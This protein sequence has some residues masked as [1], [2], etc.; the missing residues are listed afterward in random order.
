MKAIRLLAVVLLVGSVQSASAQRLETGPQ[1]LT[2]YSDVDDTEQPY[3]IYLP[4]NFDESRAYPLVVS[5]H[6]AGSNHRLNLKRVF[7]KTNT[8]GENDV[9][10]SRYF[11]EWRDVDY[12]VASPLARGT[13]GYQGVAEKDVLDMLAD[14]ER[15]FT[16]DPNRRYLTGLSMGGGGTL[17][18]GASRPDL[19]AAIVPVCPAP[20]I[21]TEPLAMN[22]LNVPVYI[23]QGDA[24]PAVSPEATRAWVKRLE[25]LGVDV[26]YE[27]YPGVGHDSWTQAYADGR[28]FDW[29]DGHVR[30]PYPDRVRLNATRYEYAKA[31]W[32]RIDALTPGDLARVDARFMGL[33]SMSVETHGV[34]GITFILEGH[35]SAT[36]GEMLDIDIDSQRLGV[37]VGE[38]VSLHR[39]AATWTPGAFQPAPTAKKAGEEGP[40]RAAVAE[41]HVYV[42][43]TADNPDPEEMEVRRL[44]AEK[45]ADWSVYRGWFMGRIGV[46]PR[47]MSDRGVRQ[48]DL[49][50]ANLVLFGTAETNTVM[51]Q[52][53]DELPLHMTGGTDTH[54]LLY[55]YPVNGRYVLVSSGIPWWKPDPSAEGG[56]FRFGGGLPALMFGEMGDF[57]LFEGHAGNRVVSGRFDTNWHLTSDAKEAFEASNIV[58]VAAVE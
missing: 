57:L 4:R 7:G 31:Y 34:R 39:E 17:W 15:R 46:Y 32:V 6:G 18:I 52:L 36:F 16:I 3:A 13:M 11:P 27:E 22:L 51:A 40:I 28:V 38:T 50:E 35:P 56:R 47:V 19:W 21:E 14:V 1:V 45:A 53:A 55:V 20:P 49:D 37:R 58:R 23:H 44:Q 24:D 54:G 9:E 41:R 43:G 26:T 25:D 5:L 33:N 12:I 2:F 48:S 42:Y 30:D 29:F 8:T 10:A